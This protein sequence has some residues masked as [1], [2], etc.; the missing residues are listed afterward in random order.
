MQSNPYLSFNGECEAAFKFYE[1]LLGGKITYS[2]TWGNS[3][4]CDAMPPEA[5]NLIMHTTLD[6]GGSLLMGADALPAQYEQPNGMHVTLHFKDA[7][8]AQRVFEA[9]AEAGKTQMPFGPT[10]F[11]V[12]FGMCADRYG[13]PWMVLAEPPQ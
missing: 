10:F 5:K 3:P 11:S 2:E 6:L 9:L 7:V 4:A 1:N 8:E 13:I 12:G